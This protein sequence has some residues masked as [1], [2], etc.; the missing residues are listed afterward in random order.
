MVVPDQE[1]PGGLVKF[2]SSNQARRKYTY[3]K[4][5]G[6]LSRIFSREFRGYQVLWPLFLKC[7]VYFFGEV[8]LFSPA[9]KFSSSK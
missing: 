8:N 7:E 5:C 2:A 3:S 1:R 9:V 4:R 6:T